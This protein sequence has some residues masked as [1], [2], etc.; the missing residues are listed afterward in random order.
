MP[1]RWNSSTG[2]CCTWSQ[3]WVEG[4]C[5]AQEYQALLNIKVKMEAEITT[6]CGLLEEGEDFNLGDALDNSQSIQK[7]TPLQDCGRQS[8]V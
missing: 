8:G 3:A 5:Q 2:S 7:T 6:Y 4:Q 1:C